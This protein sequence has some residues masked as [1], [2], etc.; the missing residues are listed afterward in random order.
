MSSITKA[1][2]PVAGWGTRRLP[3]TKVI[4]KCM[5]PV[6][7]RP[8]VD[9][10]VEDCLKAGIREI[11]FV[12]NSGSTQLQSYYSS[13]EELVT[14]LERNGKHD[15][16][17][18]IAAPENISFHYIVQPANG[19]YGTTI[20]VA[21]AA[22]N[23]A[24]GESVVV[25]MGDDFLFNPDGQSE[26]ARL[27]EAAGEA[28]SAMLGV[29]VPKDQVSRYGVL[30]LNEHEEFVQVVEKPPVDE[31]PSDLINVSK[32]VFNYEMLQE[33]VGYANED[34]SIGGE[35]L[36]TEPINRYVQKGGKLKVIPAVGQYL[37]GGTVEGW[38]HANK[39]VLGA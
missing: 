26:V 30:E 28:G 6:G 34:Q 10:V 23:L 12:V 8:I 37:D 5:L 24:Q 22:S 16:L 1:I 35:Y 4:E 31:A 36:I 9:Y 19:K 25:L 38:L 21:L 39:V 15:M 7:N 33:I 2:I 3:I 13:N 17:P 11:Y 27:I 32:Y 29:S 18:L 14:Y 20:P